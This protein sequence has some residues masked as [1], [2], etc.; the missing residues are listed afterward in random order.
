MNNPY[1]KTLEPVWQATRDVWLNRAKLQK[2]TEEIRLKKERGE[3]TIPGWSLPGIHPS[4]SCDLSS[5]ISYVCWI[6]TINFAFTNFEKPWNKFIVE[7]PEGTLWRGALAMQA[8]FMRSLQEGIPVTDA[9]YMSSISLKDVKYIFRSIDEQHRIPMLKER[10]QIFQEVGRVL[11]EKF[12]RRG[13]EWPELFERADFRAFNE[14]KGIVDLLVDYFPSFRDI[15]YY[16]GYCLEFHKRAQ[17]LVVMYYGRAFNSGGRFPLIADIEDIGPICDYELPKALASPDIGVLE[18]SSA[19]RAL[20]E[21]RHIFSP[22]HPMEKDNRLATAYAL[23]EICDGA[24]IHIP[25]VDYYLWDKGRK[26]SI[27][28]ILIPTIDY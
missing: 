6:N 27:P 10:W 17:L 12:S 11:L 15:R 28:H 25:L 19:M 5:W 18:Y 16:R 14:G 1:I 8:C 22:G 9:Q 24:D 26:S 21:R 13:K 7:Y 3:L 20:I 4:L 23:K 2:L